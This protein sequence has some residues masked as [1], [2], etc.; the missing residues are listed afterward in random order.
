MKS[1]RKQVADRAMRLAVIF[2]LAAL[3]AVGRAAVP[4]ALEDLGNLEKGSALEAVFYRMMDTPGGA[5]AFR[6]P[7]KETRASLNELAQK[8]P[9]D[10]SLFMLRALED[11]R[12]LDFAAAENDWKSYVEKSE[13]KSAAQLNLADF[14]ER[15]LR[16]Q[17]ELRVLEAVGQSASPASEALIAGPRQREWAAFERALDVVKR[18]ALGDETT[19][20]IYREWMNRYP[21]E[22][23]L[24]GRYFEFL[25]ATKDYSSAQSEIASYGKKFPTDE[26]FPVKSQAL[27]SYRRGSIDEGLAVYEKSF[28]PL[29]PPELVHSFF[30]L[31]KATHTERQF[32]DRARAALTANPDDLNAMTRILFY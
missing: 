21:A 22:A 23:S 1:S 31:M 32:L 5:V 4:W 10:A 17:D 27:L 15:R 24:E 14:Y 7:V 6:R 20:R 30:D 3:A 26:V 19:K 28:R 18:Q 25:L 16:P 8:S 11:E 29:W 13:D 2:L 9:N 12:Q